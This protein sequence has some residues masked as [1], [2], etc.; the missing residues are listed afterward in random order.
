MQAALDAYLEGSAPVGAVVVDPTGNVVSVG[1]NGF[2]GDRLAHAETQALKA[3]PTDA[4]RV[5]LSLYS[6]ME[7]CP[8]CTGA[9]RMMQLRSLHIANK[10]PAAGST[11][12]NSATTVMRH[13][14]GDVVGPT[15]PELEF[16]NVALT[17]EYRSR[18]GH[19]RWRDKW[20]SYM[21][22]AVEVG[23]RLASDRRFSAWQNDETPTSALFEEVCSYVC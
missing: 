13:L 20:V 3:V 2:S 11:E 19:T 15:N 23:E 16:V 14:A 21:P 6:T 9:I 17:L 18:N 1:R 22:G 5:E 8:M 7:P 12:H 10:E 4:R